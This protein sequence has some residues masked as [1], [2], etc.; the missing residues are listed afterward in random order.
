[1]KLVPSSVSGPTP[2]ETAARRRRRALRPPR[3]RKREREREK[4]DRERRFIMAAPGGGAGRQEPEEWK[5]ASRG[6]A[7]SGLR[8]QLRSGLPSQRQSRRVYRYERPTGGDARADWPLEG[9][10]SRPLKHNKIVELF[11]HIKSYV[12]VKYILNFSLT[13]NLCAPH[14]W[15]KLIFAGALLTVFVRCLPVSPPNT[16]WPPARLAPSRGGGGGSRGTPVLYWR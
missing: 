8:T 1:M 16:A 2:T 4:R 13:C 10:C 12:Y 14:T 9:N 7:A 15:H 3:R 11:T 6:G 5:S